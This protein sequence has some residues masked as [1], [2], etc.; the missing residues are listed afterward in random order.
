MKRWSFLLFICLFTFLLFLSVAYAADMT[1]ISKECKITGMR[2]QDATATLVDGKVTTPFRWYKSTEIT[3]TPSRPVY[4]LYLQWDGVPSAWQVQVERGGE[5][6]TVYTAGDGGYYH[7]YL[8]MDGLNV[9]FKILTA[10]DEALPPLAEM[11][12]LGEGDLPGWVQVW[13]ATPEK[14]ELMVLSTHCDDEL[15]FMGG[16]LPTYT[17]VEG[18]DTVVVYM[19]ASSARRRHEALDGLWECGV[20]QYPVFGPF[21]DFRTETLADAYSKW[22][23]EKARTFVMGVIRQYK[24]DVLVTHDTKGE[25]GHGA[26]RLTADVVLACMAE[27]GRA[28]FM[29]DSYGQWGAWLPLKCYLHLYKENRITL[30][31]DIPLERF[32]GRTG[33]EVADDAFAFHVSQKSIRYRAS[34]RGAYDCAIWGLAYTQVGIDVLGNDLFE[35]IPTKAGHIPE[36]EDADFFSF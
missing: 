13:E 24:P 35:N 9:P 31:F 12:I 8:A 3:I 7:E 36:Y 17:G 25:Y 16:I 23:K 20:R 19:C 21:R 1:D 6:V 33:R 10:S 30:D 28:D 26:H 5:W 15:V 4:G 22:G 11:T 32:G 14:A 18:R 2:R 34:D 29:P 27:G